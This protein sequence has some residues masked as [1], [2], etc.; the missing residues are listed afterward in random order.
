M[1]G[2]KTHNAVLE[3]DIYAKDE[4]IETL[5]TEIVLESSPVDL[6]YHEDRDAATPK[7]GTNLECMGGMWL[8]EAVYMYI[9]AA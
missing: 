2:I 8:P 5:N 7:L 6:E 3:A 4:K 9:S 1:N